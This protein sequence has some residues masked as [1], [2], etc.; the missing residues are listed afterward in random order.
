VTCPTVRIH[1]AV[2][3]QALAA[4]VQTG[5]L[6]TLGV[7]TGEALNEHI[8]GDPWPPAKV[9]REMLEEAV[10]VMRALW[11]GDT[12]NHRGRHYT[13][14]GARIYTL[15]QEPVR[16]YVSGARERPHEAARAA[17]GGESDDPTLETANHVSRVRVLKRSAARRE[18]ASLD[19][20]RPSGRRSHPY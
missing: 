1:P 13:V 12:V 6:L 5:G 15:P 9:R 7:G 14:D 10:E 4:A 18:P 11:T 16:V 3:A 8:L 19:L 17:R 20:R 2:V